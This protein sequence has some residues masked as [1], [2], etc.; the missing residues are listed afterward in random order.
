MRLARL[1]FRLLFLV[2]FMPRRHRQKPCRARDR[3]FTSP[4]KRP[5]MG[6]N[7]QKPKLDC[8]SN[9]GQRR[10]DEIRERAGRTSNSY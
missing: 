2:E 9:G 3:P 4:A 10:G 5:I 6:D 8:L 1:R 7:Q